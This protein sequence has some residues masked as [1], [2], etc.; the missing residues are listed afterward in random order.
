ML[1][2]SRQPVHKTFK[3]PRSLLVGSGPSPP[4]PSFT[5]GLPGLLSLGS[6]PSRVCSSHTGLALPHALQASFPPGLSPGVSVYYAFPQQ[7]P[8]CPTSSAWVSLQRSS[9]LKG[10]PSP[11]YIS[12]QALPPHLNSPSRLLAFSG[13]PRGTRTQHVSFCRLE[14]QGKGP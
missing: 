2:I 10:L 6:P 3:K 7:A 9:P 14:T 12:L 13:S 11:L 8:R 5:P 4:I 1:V